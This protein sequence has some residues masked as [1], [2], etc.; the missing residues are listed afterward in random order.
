MD[1]EHT[2][3]IEFK[4]FL[5]GAIDVKETLSAHSIEAA[6]TVFAV[7]AEG[8]ANVMEIRR[9]LRTEPERFLKV[10]EEILAD[11]E[12]SANGDIELDNLVK[13]VSRK[14]QMPVPRA[15]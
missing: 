10:W 2:G 11:A 13:V 6:L 9:M 1:P 4:A 5:S 15:V 14:A 3:K 7:E 8:R 12:K